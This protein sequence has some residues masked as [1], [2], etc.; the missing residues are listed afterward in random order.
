[1]IFIDRECD[2]IAGLF[3]RKSVKSKFPVYTKSENPIFRRKGQSFNLK[4]VREY[5]PFDDLRQIDWKLYGRTDR[6]YIKEFYEEENEG[7]LFLVDRSASLGFFDTLY[8][9]RFIASLAY[10]FLK[11]HFTIHLV[12]FSNRL[13]EASRNIKE[14]KNIHRVLSFL[15]RLTFAEPTD[16]VSVLRT[17]RQRYAPSTVLLFSDFFDRNYRLAA[18]ISFRRSFLLHF[19][20]SLAELSGDAGDLEIEDRERKRRLHIAFNRQNQRRVREREER[21]VQ[22]LRARRSNSHHYLLS[23]GA[24]RVPFYWRVLED[25]YA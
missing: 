14:V 21:F 19:F 4:N 7:M 15:D 2:T 13:E 5:Q 23:R 18:E 9:K 8:Y 22:S 25:L 24:D 1:M 12:S 10:I 17:V 6:Y 11:L 16:L 3:S 20:T